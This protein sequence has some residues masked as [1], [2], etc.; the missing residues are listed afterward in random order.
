MTTK[1]LNWDQYRQWASVRAQLR[2]SGLAEREAGRRA[3][4]ALAC[5]ASEPH[6]PRAAM[7]TK[8]A[9]ARAA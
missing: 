8:A 5:K 6:A 7:H 2:R 4:S 9:S 3:F 1:S